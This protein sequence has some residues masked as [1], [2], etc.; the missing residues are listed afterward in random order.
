M[1]TKLTAT[2][3]LV[4]LGISV[5]TVWAG[6]QSLARDGQSDRSVASEYSPPGRGRSYPGGTRFMEQPLPQDF[7]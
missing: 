1:K 4:C 3:S 6:M 5:F 7:A 2:I